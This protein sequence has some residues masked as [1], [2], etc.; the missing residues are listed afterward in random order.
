MRLAGGG[1]VALPGEVFFAAGERI[2]R[3]IRARPACVAACAH[4]YVG[5][6]P[7]AEAYPEGGYEVEESHRYT[8]LW[9]LAPDSALRLE[10]A[11]V[12]LWNEL[13]EST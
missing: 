3:Q 6:V 10:K 5:Y 9:R 1:L 12:A 7:T 13:E 8:G 4:G 11:A 2:A